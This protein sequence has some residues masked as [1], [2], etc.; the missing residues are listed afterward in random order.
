MIED[1]SSKQT[2]ES[3]ARDIKQS[4]LGSK[5]PAL[6]GFLQQQ[7]ALLVL[8]VIVIFCFIR[9]SNFDT[10][11]IYQVLNFN[12]QIG[13]IALGMTFVIMTG[14]ID[15]SVGA[16]AALS[17][18]VV[19]LNSQHGFWIAVLSGVGVGALV[20]AINGISVAWLR[21]P[22]FIVTLSTL[23]AVRGISLRLINDAANV[24]IN[25][26]S[27]FITTGS[28]TI[29][30][31]F[32]EYPMPATIPLL[33]VAFIIGMVVLR[34]T[35]FGRYVLAVGGNSDASR[36]MGLPVD[37]T[38]FSVYTLS[39]ALSGLSGV[40]I[41]ISLVGGSATEANGWELAAIASVVVGGTLL[42]GGNGSVFGTL[43]G[44]LLL[45]LIVYM[46]NLEQYYAVTHNNAG[47]NLSAFWQNI[48]RGVFLL[49]V[50]LLQSLLQK[51]RMRQRNLSPA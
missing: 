47:L 12:A 4:W 28:K 20:G 16:V 24:L 18:V 45:G 19:A 39:G 8:I 22:P 17:S 33:F 42:S 10:G 11:A 31:G 27:E 50:V 7:A 25:G 38:I 1:S 34:Y 23:F 14:G 3:P 49:I 15:L 43:V 51:R 21:I 29:G 32:L 40:L 48:I 41:A 46:L 26:H 13:L 35:R 44:V 9:Y 5:L 37:R 36:L 30:D 2:A 6:V